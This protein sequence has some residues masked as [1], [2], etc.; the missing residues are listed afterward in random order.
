MLSEDTKLQVLHDH[1]KDSFTN[2]KDHLKLRDRLFLLILTLVVLMLFQIFSPKESGEVISH[3]IATKLGLKNPINISFIG[4]IIW[5][6][7]LAL[8]TRYYQTVANLE[9]QY[10]YIHKLEEQIA[11][12]YYNKV[13]TREGMFY[14]V[15]YPL[16]LKWTWILYTIIFPVLLLIVV[17]V[18]IIG[19][20]SHAES[21][22]LLLW[23]NIAI[24]LCILLSTLFYLRLVH[25]RK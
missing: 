10:E 5:F 1:Y 25:F 20:L 19:E 21:V 18:K 8:V 2:I 23:I 11:P 9:R 7:M 3:F 4:S 13:F 12:N 6:S 16:F 15:N 24:F 22:S 17:F 14:L